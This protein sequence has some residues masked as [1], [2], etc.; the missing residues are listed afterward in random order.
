[1]ANGSSFAFTA[2]QWYVKALFVYKCKLLLDICLGP[3]YKLMLT[4]ISMRSLS[5]R[6]YHI[7]LLLNIPFHLHWN[8]S[9]FRKPYHQCYFMIFDFD[10][11][12]SGFSWLCG[13]CQN[14]VICRHVHFATHFSALILIYYFTSLL[15]LL[16]SKC[17]KHIC[18][19]FCTT[20]FSRHELLMPLF[21]LFAAHLFYHYLLA[22]IWLLYLTMMRW[23]AY[24]GIF[25]FRRRHFAKASRFIRIYATR[26]TLLNLRIFTPQHTGAFFISQRRSF[27]WRYWSRERQWNFSDEFTSMILLYSW[28]ITIIIII[29]RAFSLRRTAYCL[30][31]TAFHHSAYFHY[32]GTFLI[33]PSR[34][35]WATTFLFT[36]C[37]F[38]R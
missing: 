4:Y 27:I 22:A 20:I 29:C 15:L 35:H 25:E 14:F 16:L 24:A 19:K 3:I 37:R 8:F 5:I 1:M 18:L 12:A 32:K 17:A 30:N 31:M 6:M 34:W 23:Y 28:N 10:F 11:H 13:D 26:H 33:S 21:S 36:L 7:L 2:S 9:R 38:R